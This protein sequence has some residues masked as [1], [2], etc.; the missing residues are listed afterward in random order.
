MEVSRALVLGKIISKK[1]QEQLKFELFT[2]S[3]RA[4]IVPELTAGGR[5]GAAGV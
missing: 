3:S 4:E 2:S 1:R 5:G